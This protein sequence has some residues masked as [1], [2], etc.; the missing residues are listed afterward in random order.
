MNK[1]EEFSGTDYPKIILKLA[2][3]IDGYLDDLNTDRLILSSEEDKLA[4]DQL[5]SEVDAILVGANTIRKDDP[6]LLIK[7]AEYIS[8]RIQNNLT[9]QPWRIV[10]SASGI[11]PPNSKIFSG[12]APTIIF[13]DQLKIPNPVFGV[14]ILPLPSSLP[15]LMKQLKALGINQLLVEGGANLIN[16]LINL[17]LFDQLRLAIAP[18]TLGP[19]P[20]SAPRFNITKLLSL[21]EFKS[22]QLGTTTINWFKKKA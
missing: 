16:Q 6:R 4:V 12:E 17:E 11:L 5:R 13:C 9:N 19:L 20:I 21:K 10:I 18:I 15:E 8:Q 3:S 22:E 7:N 1:Q 2:I 14:K